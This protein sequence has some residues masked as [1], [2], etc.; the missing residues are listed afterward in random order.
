[1]YFAPLWLVSSVSY[2]TALAYSSVSTVN[3]ISASSP[4]FVL[5]FGAF[6]GKYSVD[7]FSWLKLLMVLLNML[8]VC[9]VSRFS[10]NLFTT[11]LS[12]FSAFSNAI[13][14]FAL[15]RLSFKGKNVNMPL[16]LGTVGLFSLFA[17]SPLI[18][19]AHISGFESQLPLPT[20]KQMSVLIANAF[21]GTLFAD[22]I[23]LYA[24]L[25]TG[26]LTSS[27][28]GSLGV[29]LSLLAD[30]FFRNQPP[31]FWQIVASVPIMISFFGA[32]ILTTRI[33]ES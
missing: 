8:G 16:L 22:S 4:L 5:I 24:T 11:S 9:I 31:N 17:C 30:S 32:S 3:L 29:P 21:L 28:S 19:I 14:L 15:A 27:L 33:P 2:Q 7:S 26:S 25:L 6:F 1:M 20:F 23:W 12:L 13:Y 18:Y 10:G